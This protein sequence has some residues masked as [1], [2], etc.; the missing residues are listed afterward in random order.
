MIA[1]ILELPKKELKEL[2]SAYLYRQAKEWARLKRQYSQATESKED[3]EINIYIFS[4]IP[5]LVNLYAEFLLEKITERDLPER[6]KVLMEKLLLEKNPVFES[7]PGLAEDFLLK[8]IYVFTIFELNSD[9]R[10]VIEFLNRALR[11]VRPKTSPAAAFQDDKIYDL[12]LKTEVDLEEYRAKLETIFTSSSAKKTAYIVAEAKKS[13]KDSS[14]K[15]SATIIGP[16][17]LAK[18]MAAWH[19]AINSRIL[20]IYYPRNK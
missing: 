4:L 14:E 10:K 19:E 15:I 13:L 7:Q 20:E 9:R 1:S 11:F 17:E 16:K 12:F 18:K 2:I 5:D 8:S 3:L 6:M